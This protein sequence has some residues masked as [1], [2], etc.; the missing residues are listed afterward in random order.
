MTSGPTDKEYWKPFLQDDE[1]LLW[2]GSPTLGTWWP[3][4]L[5]GFVL[6]GFSGSV[7]WSAATFN[8][9]VI[10]YCS[11]YHSSKCSLVY[12]LAWP[13]LIASYGF[14]LALAFIFISLLTGWMRHNYAL[15]NLR[16]ISVVRKVW[17]TPSERQHSIELA[18][19][20]A[21][22]ERGLVTFLGK[23]NLHFVGLSR[24][25]R[26]EVIDFMEYGRK[27]SNQ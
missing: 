9:N 26:S 16:A 25:Q 13:L 23:S 5:G 19:V 1:R 20:V 21:K 12:V 10:E 3:T 11:S 14:I 18:R 17:R 4:L 24:S 8:G 2:S 6:S 7:F 22:N 15:T 27:E